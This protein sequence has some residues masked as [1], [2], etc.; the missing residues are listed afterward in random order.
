VD[1]GCLF[2]RSVSCP[3]NGPP[4]VPPLPPFSRPLESERFAHVAA[5]P[6][7]WCPLRDSG[8]GHGFSAARYGVTADSV[9]GV[10]AV[11]YNATSGSHVSITATRSNEF[12][13]LLAAMMGGMG[14][15]YGVVTSLQLAAFPVSQVCVSMYAWVCVYV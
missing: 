2:P 13:D 7:L 15:N 12:A 1:E 14:G 5:S 4:H 6:S 8:G 9:V 11:V 10:E 3:A